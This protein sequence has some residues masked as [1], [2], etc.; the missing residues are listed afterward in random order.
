MQQPPYHSD[1]N[2][3]ILFIHS[4]KVSTSLYCFRFFC[5]LFPEAVSVS[6]MIFENFTKLIEQRKKP[7]M[8]AF[9]LY[10][11]LLMWTKPKLILRV[12]PRI[13]TALAR[14]C[15]DWLWFCG[16]FFGSRCR[17][18]LLFI[19]LH[20]EKCT[21]SYRNCECV[22]SSMYNLQIRF[23]VHFKNGDMIKVVARRRPEQSAA[24]N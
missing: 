12:G 6:S 8:A 18:L 22:F 15:W 21:A 16:P 2:A 20:N 17:I 11:Q 7:R 5:K 23:C 13:V 1:N 3:C 14:A 9:L 24:M 19:P 4:L 10:D